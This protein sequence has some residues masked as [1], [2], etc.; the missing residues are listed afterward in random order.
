MTAF[1]GI[2]HSKDTPEWRG[3]QRY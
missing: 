1:H 2:F 3:P